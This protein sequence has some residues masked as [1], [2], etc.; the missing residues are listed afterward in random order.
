[1]PRNIIIAGA[2]KSGTTSLYTYLS[3]HPDICGSNIK[4][5]HYFSDKI[6]K[7]VSK[8][9]N[10]YD[11]FFDNINNSLYLLEA[12]PEYIYGGLKV[13]NK[14][15]NELSDPLI[16][17]ILRNPVDK[18]LS[19]FNHRKKQLIFEK[20]YSFD[21][22]FNTFIKV[23]NLDNL[24]LKNQYLAEMNDGC[25][26]KYLIDF[27]KVFSNDSIKIIFFNDLVKNP[28]SVVHN[29]LDAVNLDSSIY[30]NYKFRV[31]NKS[32]VYKN[33]LIHNLANNIYSKF[34]PFMRK[35]YKIKLFLRKIYYFIN[36]IDNKD[37]MNDKNKK[38]LNLL[39]DKHN[40][41]LFDFLKSKNYNNFPT[42]LS[43]YEE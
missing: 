23:D 36:T 13:A 4:E 6:I 33:K 2:H 17:F 34:E 5:T 7:G 43:I 10:N 38:R 26:I 9:Y 21:D 20:D 24:D 32:I 28:K 39:Y 42:W 22:F 16:I 35:N 27:Y 30:D 41:L 14:I 31:E 29:I 19:S 37:K 3:Y 40:K 8:K 25:Y 15:K 18:F 1:M 12:S 11:D